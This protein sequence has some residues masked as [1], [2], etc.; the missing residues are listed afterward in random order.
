MFDVKTK[1]ELKKGNPAVFREVFRLLYPRLKGYCKLFISDESEV[2]DIV[3]E[4]FLTFWEKHKSINTGKRI[5]S[6][7]FVMVRNRCLN[8][9]KSSRLD[10][11]RISLDN[12]DVQ[13]LQYLYQLDLNEKEEK[14]L[15]EMLVLSFREAINNLP[16]K[17]KTVFVQC[18]LEGRKQ[19]EVAEE[20]GISQKMIE[21]QIAKAKSQIREQL[22]KQYP[23]LV[24]LVAMLLE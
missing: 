11:G 12:L 18:K 17:M 21:K 4:S 7:L 1:S 13:E 22:M 8:Y 16:D 24:V 3:Q 5:E 23:T 9:L 19:K 15:E 6:L 20:L 2:E 10:W 14:S